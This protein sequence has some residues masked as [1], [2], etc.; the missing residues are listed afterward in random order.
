M[1]LS[2][3]QE[4]CQS[5]LG[6]YATYNMCQRVRKN[7]PKEKNGSYVEEFAS[8]WGYAAE[9]IASNPGSTVTIQVDRDSVGIATFHRMYICLAAG[10]I[11][12]LR[13]SF[14]DVEHRMCA[15][16]IYANWF[17]KWRGMNR[18]IQ[19]WNCVKATFVEDFDLQIQGLEALG[20]TSSNDLF[21]TPV[22]HWSKAYF[23]ATSKYDV[24]DNNMAEAFNGWIVEARAKPII[25]MLEQIRIIV[26]SRMT[27]KR[28]WAEK[29]RTNISPRAL[30]KLERNMSTSNQ[31]RLVWNGDG[32]FEMTHLDNQD[33]VDL[34]KLSC[35]CKEWEISG[36]PCYHA[37]CAMF[38]DSKSPEDYVLEWYSKEKYMESYK[39]VLQPMRGKKFWPKGLPP[40]LP[41]TVKVQP[42]RPKKKRIK[43]KDEPKKMKVGKFTKE[44]ARIRCSKC[45]TLGH[46]IQNCSQKSTNVASS[47]VHTNE[48]V[49]RAS[50]SHESISIGQTHVTKSTTTP[51]GSKKTHVH[52]P[53]TRSMSFAGNEPNNSNHGQPSNKRKR[54]IGIVLYTNLRTGEQIFNSSLGSQT[55]I[56]PPTNAPKKIEASTSQ[57]DHTWKGPG[58]SLKGKKVVTTRQ[59]QLELSDASR[60]HP[61]IRMTQ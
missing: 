41:P 56:T 45:R 47:Q 14:P 8:L 61:Q 13:E 26:M 15:R 30:E 10:L 4:M 53:R 32:G 39:H 12:V 11:P 9:L 60:K 57:F 40:I 28:N 55:V 19:F 48:T 5:E 37:I 22:Q 31:C 38:H 1:K 21:A 34:K 33:I 6:A 17:K 7:V 59:L 50:Q 36:I 16:H 58:L 54:M 51:S 52:R 23:K 20:P 3:L 35:T 24:V 29:W 2:T 49:Y 42:G 27:V 25:S 43:A 46:N 44:G 18:K